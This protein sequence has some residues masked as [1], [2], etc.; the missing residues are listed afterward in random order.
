MCE[1]VFVCVCGVVSE[2]PAAHWQQ[3]QPA[4]ASALSSTHAHSS[5]SRFATTAGV[6]RGA[7]AARG[8]YPP[9][10]RRHRCWALALAALLLAAAAATCVQQRRRQRTCGSAGCSP[11]HACVGL[12]G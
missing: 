1:C 12:C 2:A 9:S 4:A 10:S 8:S 3:P 5:C 6:W 7:M 11:R